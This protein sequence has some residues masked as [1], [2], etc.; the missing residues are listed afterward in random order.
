V[1]IFGGGLIGLLAAQC[2]YL[3]G[4]SRIGIIEPDESRCTLARQVLAARVLTVA[5]DVQLVEWADSAS[6]V[7]EASGNPNAVVDVLS[8]APR[9]ARVVLLGSSRGLTP[10][11]SYFET[12]HKKAL[13]VIGAHNDARPRNE[14]SRGHWTQK[15]DLS[16]ALELLSQGRLGEGIGPVE[17]YKSADVVR[18][19]QGLVEKTDAPIILIEW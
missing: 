15:D 7:V 9:D 18:L 12:I 8:A 11:L 17:R 3:A 6:V 2:A 14:S 4:A 19:Y 1:I 5:E 10:A 16:V 13:T